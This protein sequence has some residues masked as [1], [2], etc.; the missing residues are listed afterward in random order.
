[1]LND[2]PLY[3]HVDDIMSYSV[4]VVSKV[5]VRYRFTKEEYEDRKI[6]LMYDLKQFTSALPDMDKKS[7]FLKSVALHNILVKA[8]KYDYEAA[9][10]VTSNDTQAKKEY[11][12]SFTAYGAFVRRKA[13]CSGYSKAFKILCDHYG[14]DCFVALGE[15][16]NSDGSIGER[17]A[18]NI[19]RIG[20]SYIHIDTTWDATFSQKSD[21]LRFDFFGMTDSECK[22][23][24]KYSGYPAANDNTLN[25]FYSTKRLINNPTELK[26][27]FAKAQKE[28]PDTIYF[29]LNNAR[30]LTPEARAKIDELIHNNMSKILASGGYYTQ[31]EN[32]ELSIF[33][34][35]I[36][37]SIPTMLKK[38]IKNKY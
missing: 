26:D 19:I 14:I 32:T 15:H 25:Y 30:N 31:V 38:K 17:H 5:V 9:A 6:S 28:K 36:E 33:F 20:T 3:F 34:F 24:R 16:I 22:L 1:M 27:F 35:N 11:A 12:D 10:A 29:K 21:A 7:A 13:V 2:N 23:Q 8:V 18:W 37:Y 4:S